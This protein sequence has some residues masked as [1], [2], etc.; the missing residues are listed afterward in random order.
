ML[1]IRTGEGVEMGR[2]GGDARTFE[3]RGVVLTWSGASRVDRCD[4]SADSV[5][6]T[7]EQSPTGFVAEV[8]VDVRAEGRR[9]DVAAFCSATYRIVG[10]R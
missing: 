8:H 4:V 9:C 7:V 1:E 6:E 3:D 2:P 10:R 5:W